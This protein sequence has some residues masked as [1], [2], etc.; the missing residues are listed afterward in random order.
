MTKSL[1]EL[2]ID[3]DAHDKLLGVIH[4][5]H[6][7]VL[8]A[9]PRGSGKTT[10][11][12]ACLAE[13]HLAGAKIATVEDPV[14]RNVDGWTQAHVRGGMG[15]TYAAVLREILRQAPDVVM[16]GDMSDSETAR[17]A[18]NA[19]ATSLVF[20]ALDAPGAVQTI[21]RLWDMGVAPEMIAASLKGVL[22]QRLVRVL[23]RHCRE[24]YRPS[25]DEME[26]LGLPDTWRSKMDL[27]GFRAKGCPACDDAGYLGHTGLF[28]FM[29]IDEIL[30]GL[31]L[32][33]SAPREMCKH[34]REAQ[35]VRT[36][37]QKGIIRWA[38]GV[39]SAE[40][41]LAHTNADDSCEGSRHDEVHT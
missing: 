3:Q 41:V 6:G 19:S 13:L 35:G 25:T 28:E 32:G 34:V 36:P 11:L 31:I 14:E 29:V 9:G 17:L 1:D 16:I 37:R 5:P 21:P 18:L 38:Q 22:A 15:T 2:G 40:E 26:D 24:S 27:R 33:C 20:G 4:N 7:A 23:C 10:T 8:V 39:T 12:Y 30:N